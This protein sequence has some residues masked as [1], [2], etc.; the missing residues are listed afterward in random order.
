[1]FKTNHCNKVLMILISIFISCQVAFG[2]EPQS[3]NSRQLRDNK[4]VVQRY[5]TEIIDRM[6]TEG[7]TPAQRLTR[8]NELLGSCC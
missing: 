8:S 3:A 4:I 5:F 7:L 2:G 1:M 6:G